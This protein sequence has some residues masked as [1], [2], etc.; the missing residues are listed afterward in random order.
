MRIKRVERSQYYTAI[1]TTG[2]SNSK[3]LLIGIIRNDTFELTCTWRVQQTLICELK[4]M[5]DKLEPPEDWRQ[6]YRKCLAYHV[7]KKERMERLI[8]PCVSPKSFQTNKAPGSI[9]LLHSQEALRAGLKS[10]IQI[11]IS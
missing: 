1:H 2:K 6:P 7:S 4:G 9:Y 8:Y 10:N 11:A 3:G 5:L